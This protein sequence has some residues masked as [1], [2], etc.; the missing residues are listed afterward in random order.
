MKNIYNFQVQLRD[1]DVN[2]PICIVLDDVI[3]TSEL[4]GMKI[5]EK[6]FV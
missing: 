3:G 5:L 4:H 6:M 2:R 1:Y